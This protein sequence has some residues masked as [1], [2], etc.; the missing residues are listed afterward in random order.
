MLIINFMIQMLGLMKNEKGQGMV[1]YALLVAL[2]AIVVIAAL[3][4]LGPQIAA[5]FNNIVTELQT[6]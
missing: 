4:V 1:E 6:N 5:E 2:I 3:L